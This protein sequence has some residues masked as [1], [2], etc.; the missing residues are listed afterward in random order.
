MRNLF[1]FVLVFLVVP[2]MRHHQTFPELAVA[3]N[4]E[5]QQLM[6]DHVVAKRALQA[7]QLIIEAQRSRRGARRPLSAHRAHI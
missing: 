7:E 1:E 3:W 4:R 5:V 6:N 2:A